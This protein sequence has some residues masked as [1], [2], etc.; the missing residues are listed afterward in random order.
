MKGNDDERLDS[1]GDQNPNAARQRS[2]KPSQDQSAF[3]MYV[4]SQGQ[5]Q[6]KGEIPSIAEDVHGEALSAQ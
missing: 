2:K 6:W 1:N 5:S 3:R 4:Q